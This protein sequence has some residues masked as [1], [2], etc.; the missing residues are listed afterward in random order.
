MVVSAQDNINV[1]LEMNSKGFNKGTKEATKNMSDLEKG[2]DKS[3]QRLAQFEKMML[4]AGLAALFTGMAIKNAAQQALNATF[5]TFSE[6]TEGTMLYNQSIGRLSA[7]FEFLK[8][9]IADAFLTSELGMALLDVVIGLFDFISGLPPQTQKFIAGL[10]IVA[11]VLGTILMIAGQIGLALLG[12]TAVFGTKGLAV[13]AAFG[14]ALI[15]PLYIAIGLMAA[16]IA[17]S[18]LGGLEFKLIFLKAIRAIANAFLHLILTPVRNFIDQMNT[19][20]KLVK[21]GFRLP[22]ISTPDFGALGL[23][24]EIART[25]SAIAG[26]REAESAARADSVNTTANNFVIDVLNIRTDAAGTDSILS[27]LTDAAQRNVGA[28]IA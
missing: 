5:K 15:N 28:G 7:A 20:F 25:E 3:A 4:G 22:Q 1:N 21:V 27:T 19:I 10:L 8:F 23:N 26:N 9:S 11:V 17:L 14:L 12:I 13:V 2:L 6:V 16:F 18:A 24:A